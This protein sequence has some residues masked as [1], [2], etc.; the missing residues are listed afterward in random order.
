VEKFGCLR[1][2]QDVVEQVLPVN[3]GYAE[4]RLW[5]VTNK[6]HCAVA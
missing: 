3:T 1:Q 5:S 4:K 2:Y 6:N